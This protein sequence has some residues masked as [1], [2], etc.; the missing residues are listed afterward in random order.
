MPDVPNR[1][2][3]D[4][5]GGG[6]SGCVAVAVRVGVGDFEG[7]AVG[8]AV[9]DEEGVALT[10]RVADGLG[11]PVGVCAAL[12]VP[13]PLAVGVPVAVGGGELEGEPPCPSC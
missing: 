1:A 4:E 13:E 8:G 6:H 10:V 9:A 3:T 11:V 5:T 2:I 7:D 12:G